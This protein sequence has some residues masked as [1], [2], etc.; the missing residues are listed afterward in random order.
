MTFEVKEHF[1]QIDRTDNANFRKFRQN[2]I[3]NKKMFEKS[4]RAFCKMVNNLRF[5][6]VNI[7]V[8]SFI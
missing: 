2:Q 4:H 5:Y 6:I 8:L 3:L 1:L 7:Y